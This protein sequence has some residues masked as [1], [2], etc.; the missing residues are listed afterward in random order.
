MALILTVAL[1]FKTVLENAH[2]HISFKMDLVL[3]IF[4]GP[5]FWQ[6]SVLSVILFTFTTTFGAAKVRARLTK[7]KEGTKAC[8]Q[9]TSF[10]HVIL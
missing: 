10:Q 2:I 5:L 4:S 6:K 3:V 7:T 1:T 9:V 8:E